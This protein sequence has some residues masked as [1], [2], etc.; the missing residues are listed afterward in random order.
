VVVAAGEKMA[1]FVGE[2]DGHQSEGEG[3]AGGEGEGIFVEESERAE[4]FVGG[5]GLVLGVGGGEL[6]AG[7]EAGA[8]REEEEEASE[9][10][11]FSGWTVGGRG[12]A[13]AVG[14][15][16]APIDA[17]RDDWRRIF[18]GRCGHEKFWA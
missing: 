4:K 10:Q 2:E 7:D 3:E 13:D 9:E 18:W 16:G 17:G 1:E 11:H 6:R 12:V 15:G 5:E 8:E 14:R